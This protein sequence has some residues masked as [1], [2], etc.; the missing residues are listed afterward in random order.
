MHKP[1][2]IAGAAAAA[3]FLTVH[4]WQLAASR[5]AVIA[6]DALIAP[7]LPTANGQSVC[8]TGAFTGQAMDI[9]D[10]S[11]A[12]LVP[13]GRL[14]PDGKPYMRN[15]PGRLPVRQVH[16]FTLSL[17][18][19]DRK[20]DY[21]WIYN[22]RLAA[23]VDGIGATLFAAGECPW[24]AR[25][26]ANTTGLGCGIDC[27]GG[28]FGLARVAGTQSWR[29]HFDPRFALRMKAGCGGGGTFGLRAR[30]ED[31]AFRLEPASPEACWLIDA[32]S[33][34]R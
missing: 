22:F 12:R 26:D 28:G 11:Q 10:W 30:T 7:L 9:E 5:Y 21:D 16:S 33:S 24:Y 2:L 29:M 27:D 20:A 14:A 8:Y 32:R 3:G 13:T 34:A 6:P 17:T 18:Y 4:G 15:E 1:W 25:G 23:E 19:D 31:T